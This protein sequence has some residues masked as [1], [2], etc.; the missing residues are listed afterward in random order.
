MKSR[1]F[2]FATILILIVAAC[3]P[4]PN[5][6]DDAFLN[7]VSLLSDE[8][9]EAPCWRNITPGET[10]WRDALIIIE[11]DSG[12]TNIQTE[13]APESDARLMNFNAGDGAQCCRIFSEDGETI[14]A[15]LTL[16]APQMTLGDIIDKY[17]EPSYLTGDDVTPDQALVSIVYPDANIVL[18]VFGAGITE[19]E[20]TPA[21]EIIGA[22]YLS[23]EEMEELL[24]TTSLYDWE[25]FGAIS[26]MIDGEFDLLPTDDP[27]AT[28]EATAETTSE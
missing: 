6:R 17:G 13:N 1:V 26:G 23:A 19:G 21:S 24:F 28:P 11:D 25:G 10:S 7:D 3:A 8:P 16:L 18:Y 14:S 4:P 12:L 20:L 22:I 2:F 15:I 5:L 9:C 27:E